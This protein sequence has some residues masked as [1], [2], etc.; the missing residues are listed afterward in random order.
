MG[1]L[2]LPIGRVMGISLWLHVSWFPVLVLASWAASAVFADAYPGLPAGERLAMG[3]VTGL[4]F[5]A[6]L[7][8]HELSH[9]VVARR[10][11][12]RVRGITLFLFGGVAEIGGELPTPEQEVEVALAG[13]A[14]SLA[15][16]SMLGLASTLA[17][18]LGWTGAEGV[19]LALAAVN[20]GV[21]VFNLAPGLPLDGGRL[22]RA[23]I[24]RAT[25]SFSRGTRAAAAV[26]RSLGVLLGAGGAFL[27][28]RG[29]AIGL[30]YAGVG[31]FLWFL[32]GRAGRAVAPALALDGEGEAAEPRP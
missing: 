22:L 32:A 17:T 3:T 28:V 23:G 25:G 26:G 11:G 6:C 18:S 4:A 15:L 8:T 19:L 24:W 16:G 29:E 30:W 2:R 31:A 5:F 10:L 9:A 12:L 14:T 21:A 13:P 20:L 27:V 7:M 1:R